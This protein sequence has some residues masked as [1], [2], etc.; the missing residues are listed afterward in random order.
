MR[1]GWK[2]LIGIVAGLIVLLVLNAITVSN[3]TKDA[4]RGQRDQANHDQQ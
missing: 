1:R 4:E 3:Q 2:I